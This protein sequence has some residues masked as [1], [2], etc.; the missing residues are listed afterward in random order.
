[1]LLH[2]FQKL[3]G[4]RLQFEKP[5]RL[6]QVAKHQQ[7]CRLFIG[8]FRPEIRTDAMHRVLIRNGFCDGRQAK[9]FALKRLC[10]Q[11]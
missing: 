8:R 5:Y 7:E 1:M 6:T 11:W 3:I 4:E 10:G 9:R 2:C